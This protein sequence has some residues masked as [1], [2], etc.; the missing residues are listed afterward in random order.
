MSV[1]DFVIHIDETLDE[2]DINDA[3]EAVTGCTGVVSAR[4]S[5]HHPHLMLV[6]YDPEQGCSA[7]ALG[8]IQSLGLHGQ[9]IGL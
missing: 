6:A 2:F 7:E 8:A 5:P 1:S 9:M 4:V 3:E